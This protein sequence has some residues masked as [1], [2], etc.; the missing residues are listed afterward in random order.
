MSLLQLHLNFMWAEKSLDK[1][2]I[3]R[4]ANLWLKGFKLLSE[5]RGEEKGGEGRWFE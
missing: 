5:R 2:L 3:A 4:G 1:E